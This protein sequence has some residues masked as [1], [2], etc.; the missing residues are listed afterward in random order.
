MFPR[1]TD[2]DLFQAALTSAKAA[3]NRVMSDTM[4]GESKQPT[5]VESS[6]APLKPHPHRRRLARPDRD[7]RPGT[8]AA[9]AQICRTPLAETR[10]TALASSRPTLEHR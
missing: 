7:R 9:R 4:L 6:T 10:A 3:W 8:I 5:P 1:L 2:R